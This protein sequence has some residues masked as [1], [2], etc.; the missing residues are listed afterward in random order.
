MVKFVCGVIVGL[1]LGYCVG[2]LTVMSEMYDG[3]YR[4]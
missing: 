4:R 3:D 1:F 2:G